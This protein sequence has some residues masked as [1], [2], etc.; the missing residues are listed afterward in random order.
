M[1]GYLPTGVGCRQQIQ[2]ADRQLVFDCLV[3]L[4]PC[5]VV[6][7]ERH[8]RAE[9]ATVDRL[10]D[11]AVLD[12]QATHAHVQPWRAPGIDD[13]LGAQRPPLGA[14]ELD[15]A[16][17]HEHAE[18]PAQLVLA[19]RG[20]VRVEDVALVEHGV[21]D[22]S[23]SGEPVPSHSPAP[24]SLSRTS[25]VSSHVTSARRALNR[26]RSSSTWRLTLTH[27]LFGK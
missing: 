7:G 5:R 26:A 27:P 16:L 10:L 11:A 9:A 1:D 24:A 18:L 20:A 6:D 4:D 17:R 2:F 3:P 19:S 22:R 14:V 25:N 15:L 12:V 21:G 23:G 8:G 13:A